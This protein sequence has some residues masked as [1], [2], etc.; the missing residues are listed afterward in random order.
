MYISRVYIVAVGFISLPTSRL[1][2]NLWIAKNENRHDRNAHGSIA[3]FKQLKISLYSLRLDSLS[4]DVNVA[5]SIQFSLFNSVHVKIGWNFFLH[6]LWKFKHLTNTSR[7]KC[8]RISNCCFCLL[9]CLNLRFRWTY[10]VI[11]LFFS[12]RKI[13]DEAFADTRKI[14]SRKIWWYKAAADDVDDIFNHRSVRER[15][16]NLFPYKCCCFRACICL[17]SG[18]ESETSKS[19]TQSPAWVLKEKQKAKQQ[20]QQRA[21]SCEERKRRKKNTR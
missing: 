18:D 4:T 8:G 17:S 2:I 6:N 13:D 19:K 21:L 9:L 14:S 15:K 5:K 10:S 3:K 20:Q 11:A 1:W 16:L 7:I 12:P